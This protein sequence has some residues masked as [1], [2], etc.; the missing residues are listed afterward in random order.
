MHVCEN[1]KYCANRHVFLVNKYFN[2]FKVEEYTVITWYK[3]CYLVS[4]W[5]QC[6]SLGLSFLLFTEKEASEGERER[7]GEKGGGG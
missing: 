7:G 1:A 5:L 6:S 3:Q 4:R 2:I